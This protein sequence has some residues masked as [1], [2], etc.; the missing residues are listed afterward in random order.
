ML[1]LGGACFKMIHSPVW[2]TMNIYDMKIFSAENSQDPSRGKFLFHP[3]G[4]T[5]DKPDVL[6]GFWAK[7]CF[8]HSA[9]RTPDKPDVVKKPL[10]GAIPPNLPRG[11][12][13]FH[14]VGQ[15]P[16]KPDTIKQ[17]LG[18][19]PEGASLNTKTP[20]PPSKEII[21][22]NKKAD[23]MFRLIIWRDMLHEYIKYKPFFGFAF[24]RPLY[25]RTLKYYGLN[26]TEECDGWV[27]AHNS[28]FYMIYRS[29]IVGVVM[30]FLILFLWFG[31][32][33]DFYLLKDHIGILLCGILLNWIVSAN[34]FLI[35][36][37]PYTAIPVWTIWGI[38]EKYRTILIRLNR[39]RKE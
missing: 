7:K 5:P 1:V 17:F 38:T 35:F 25:S 26:G 4:Q 27:G 36:E 34:F 6:G 11:K 30:V 10:S 15:T 19:K 3:V 16:G 9:G 39:M 32:L 13:L 20:G 24:G 23:S 12:V 29:G 18:L 37:L 21:L 14:P 31:L 22:S 33:R 2:A 28:F 8:F